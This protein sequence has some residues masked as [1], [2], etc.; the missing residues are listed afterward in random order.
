MPKE[1]QQLSDE[2]NYL[3]H[4]MDGIVKRH[5]RFSGN[6]AHALKTPLTIIQ[7]DTDSTLIKNQVETMLNIIDR[8]LSKAQ[9]LGTTNILSIKTPILPVVK[10]ISD[11]FGKVYQKNISIDGDKQAVFRGDEVDLYEVLGN[12]IE[13]ACKYGKDRIAITL[14]PNKII[15]EDD[16]PGIDE[17]NHEPVKQRGLRLDESIDGS[18]LGLSIANDII[19][20]Y[21]GSL[22]LGKSTLGGLQ[23]TL[24]FNL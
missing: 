11:G 6:L 16:G 22:N 10:R 7:G 2:I 8:N 21:G 23:A 4:Y 5:R 1:I 3:L 24:I 9:T 20:L 17:A 18:G 12:L 19:E 14:D 13:N 15:I